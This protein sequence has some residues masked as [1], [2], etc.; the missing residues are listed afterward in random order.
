MVKIILAGVKAGN[1]SRAP[2][3][4]F[5]VYG[6]IVFLDCAPT[7]PIGDRR[8]GVDSYLKRVARRRILPANIERFITCPRNSQ[9][10]QARIDD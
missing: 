7:F 8:Y 6:A 1:P 4:L 5:L 3:I 9:N 10:K 2:L